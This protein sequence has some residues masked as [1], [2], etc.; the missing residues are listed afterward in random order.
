MSSIDPDGLQRVLKEIRGRK[1]V[2]DQMYLKKTK[3]SVMIMLEHDFKEWII[4]EIKDQ[5]ILVDKLKNSNNYGICQ[6]ATEFEVSIKRIQK[7]Q[8][9]VCGQM[10]KYGNGRSRSKNEADNFSKFRK[11]FGNAELI[12]NELR[13]YREVLDR[14][15]FAQINI[16]E[17]DDQS[18]L[19]VA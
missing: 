18:E 3:M 9:S 1:F 17:S 7:D 13:S 15:A 2:R 19:D 14:L 6:T 12:I 16:F 5:L 4:Q 8:S 10:K 11:V